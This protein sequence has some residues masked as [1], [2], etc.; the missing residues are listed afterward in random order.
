MTPRAAADAIRMTSAR[1][2]RDDAEDAAAE[3]A[4]EH[5]RDR[6][7]ADAP[8]AAG[9]ALGLISR[10]SRETIRVFHSIRSHDTY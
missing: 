6:I 8:R 2:R 3:D 9:A 5:A 1:E 7:A 10:V 4:F